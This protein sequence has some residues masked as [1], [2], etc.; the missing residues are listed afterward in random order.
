MKKDNIEYFEDINEFFYLCYLSKNDAGKRDLFR[1]NNLL[2]KNSFILIKNN[3]K[4][5]E[6]NNSNSSKK[7]I[8]FIHNSPWNIL[9]LLYYIYIK[10]YNINSYLLVHNTLEFESRNNVLI[11]F[12]D[13]II[14]FINFKMVNNHVFLT[15]HVMNSWKN[16][17]GNLIL[18]KGNYF[19]EKKFI[20][21]QSKKIKPTIFFFGRYM[22][23]KNIEFIKKVSEQL[24]NFD[25]IIYSF[26]CMISESSN[27]TVINRWIEDNEVN[28]IYLNN[29]ILFLPYNEATQSGPLYIGLEMNK[30][31]ILSDIPEFS[32]YRKH[33]NVFLYD[34]NI[35]ESCINTILKVS[36]I[37]NQINNQLE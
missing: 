32:I 23:Y 33:E 12:I 11:S 18:T 16:R 25:F 8:F 2:I 22:K 5:V 30:L 34:K 29:D 35:V 6:D 7:N 28:D 9:F 4:E 27:L 20:N 14:L 1:I 26:G 37:Y 3:Y 19:I 24:P 13:K 21:K 15:E 31:I 10:R 36:N 17:T